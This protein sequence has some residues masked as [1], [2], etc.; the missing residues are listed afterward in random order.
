MNPVVERRETDICH[1][2]NCRYNKKKELNRLLKNKGKLSTYKNQKKM[3]CV[4]V[5]I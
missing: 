4:K 5:L 2:L 1:T 3:V